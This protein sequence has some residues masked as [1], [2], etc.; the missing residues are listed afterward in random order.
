MGWRIINKD[1][2]HRTQR[3]SI[4]RPSSFHNHTVVSVSVKANRRSIRRL[5]IPPSLFASAFCPLVLKFRQER[6]LIVSYRPAPIPVT[7]IDVY[8]KDI[9]FGHE[10]FYRVKEKKNHPSVQSRNLNGG[11]KKKT[12]GRCG[13]EH[14]CNCGRRIE[15][16]LHSN[17]GRFFTESLE[18]SLWHTLP[19]I[20]GS[21]LQYYSL[22]REKKRFTSISLQRFLSSSFFLFFPPILV[23]CFL[24]GDAFA[25]PCCYS[26]LLQASRNRK[27]G[28]GVCE[29]E[30]RPCTRVQP[31]LSSWYGV[32]RGTSESQRL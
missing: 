30:S 10:N 16:G 11:K 25:A 17:E 12:L 28:G 26:P 4:A 29:N 21:G 14:Y 5:Y 9:K 27:K 22:K 2:V 31:G 20:I 23:F 1:T 13:M 24:L 3:P 6:H 32:G 18:S 8:L 7:Y 15:I 19:Q